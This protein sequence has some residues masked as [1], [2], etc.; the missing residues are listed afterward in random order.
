MVS[1]S[2]PGDD[3][4]EELTSPEISPRDEAKLD[5]L[6]ATEVAVNDDRLDELAAAE[7]E[8][9]DRLLEDVG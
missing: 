7:D 6:L 5:E 8:T 3:E 4:L 1:I 2:V 9:L